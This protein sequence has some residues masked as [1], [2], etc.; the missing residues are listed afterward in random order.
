MASAKQLIDQAVGVN[1]ASVVLAPASDAVNT[2]GNAATLLDEA[3]T[4]LEKTLK[5]ARAVMSPTS[6]R[7]LANALR[8]INQVIDDLTDVQDEFADML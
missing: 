2:L 8:E 5:M 1:E 6:R 7:V 3:G 4:Q